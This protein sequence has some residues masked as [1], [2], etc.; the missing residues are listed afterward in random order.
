MS[1]EWTTEQ[2]QVITLRGK[3]LLVSAAAGSGKTAVLVE[4]IIG[5]I[6][7]GAHPVDIDRMLI[8]TFTS[9]AAAEMRE[10]IGNA[11]E[12]ALEKDPANAHLMKQAS[13]V[14]HAQITTIHSFCLY[15]IRN[16]FHRVDLEPNFRI[17][18]EGELNLLREDV[19]DEV[20]NRNYEL[21]SEE[22]LHFAECFASGKKDDG[23]KDLVFQM[24][25]FATSFPWPKEWLA[26]AAGNYRFESFWQ[27]EQ[28]PWMKSLL[29]YLRRVCKSL[30]Q[31][32]KE[33]EALTL[34][35]RKSVV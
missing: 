22:F 6:L 16:Y 11:I 13:L 8:V 3:N 29:L 23:L 31:T 32:A 14:H 7:D 17:A 1:M 24:Y 30:V 34:E 18:E 19:I 25:R 12:A 28:M 20:L 4:R 35:D 27:I 21:A 10:R 33:N 9:A 2:Q 15:L 26:E 5:R